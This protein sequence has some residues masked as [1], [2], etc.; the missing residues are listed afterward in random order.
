MIETSQTDFG[1]AQWRDV[2]LILTVALCASLIML[3]QGPLAGTEAQRAITAHQMVQSG[4]WMVPRLLDHLYLAKPPLHCWIIATFET[5]SGRADP[6]IWRLP[7]AIAGALTASV[8]YL[9]A[10]RWYGRLGGLVAGISSFGLL[11][12]W[13]QNHTAELDAL[14]TTACI[15]CACL[16]L[17]LGFGPRRHRGWIILAVAFSFSAALL[18]KGPAGLA[19]IIGALI[20]PAIFNRTLS[21]L[22]TPAPWIGLAAG[23]VVFL[24][25]AW[26]AARHFHALNL[27]PDTSGV[28]EAYANIFAD[29]IKN[30]GHNLVQPIE[31]FL[32]ALPVSLCL[33]LALNPAVWNES[34]DPEIARKWNDADRRL[35]RGLVGTIVVALV[36][37][38]LPGLVHPRY[39]YVWLP[40]ICPVAGA[41]AAAWSRGMF[42]GNLNQRAKEVFATTAVMFSVATVAIALLAYQRDHQNK[43]VLLFLASLVSIIVCRGCLQLIKKNHFRAAGWATIALILLAAL[44]FAVYSVADRNKRSMF[45]AAQA[46]AAKLPPHQTVATGNLVLNDPAL[47]YYARLNVESHPD[48]D[49]RPREFTDSRWVV[50]D[51]VEYHNWSASLSDRLLNVQEIE[52]PDGPIYLAWYAAP[53]DA[54]AADAQFS[55]GK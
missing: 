1:R 2:L 51:K 5:L 48:L 19:P 4:D 35:L 28:L 42:V 15:S 24:I 26:C 54:V 44:P 46:L 14:N 13:A 39:S 22:K 8:L 23:T 30:L 29:R 18:L 55:A 50:L 40:M 43:I 32:Y 3:G 7:S 27:E 34:N 20:G 9:I 53:S 6:F 38:M 36:L 21:H 33:P 52:S 17:D 25:Y 31:L 49:C 11:A 41:I 37:T 12:L 10:A 16:L 47:F 45:V